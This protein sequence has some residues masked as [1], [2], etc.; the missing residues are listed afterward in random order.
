MAAWIGALVL[1]AW[2]VLVLARGGFWRE[3]PRPP[4]PALAGRRPGVI[5]VVPARNEAPVVRRALRSLLHQRYDGPFAIIL[6]DDGSTDGTAEA[7]RAAGSA[8]RVT[9][10]AASPTPSGWTGKVWAM[11][12]GLAEAERRA[13]EAAYVLLTDADIEHGAGALDDL[14][15]RAETGGYDLVSFMVRL[16]ALTPAERILAPAYVFFFQMLYPFAWVRDRARATAA[17][18]GG[19]MLVRRSALAG[20]GGIEAIKGALIDDCA[21]A[22]ALKRNGPIW[23]GLGETSASLRG[24]P[25]MRDVWRLI[26]RSAYA[27]VRFDPLL[28]AATV[29]GMALVYLAPPVLALLGHGTA[30]ILGL[31]AWAL[32]AGAYGPTLRRFRLSVLWAPALPLVALVYLGAT[33]DSA[34][35]HA[36]GRGGSWKGRF[37]ALARR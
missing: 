13:P 10:V 32:M 25:R 16:R 22:R 36:L 11:A 29:A 6:V 34:R 31:A 14:V 15:R 5:A 8:A 7:A 26:A 23:L 2:L 3:A 28:L 24:Y 21:L 9:V 1:V 12:E 4:A 17:A 20:I 27:Q 19:C 33:L 35:L 37:Q 30:R 18:A